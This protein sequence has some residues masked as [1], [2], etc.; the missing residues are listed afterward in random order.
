MNNENNIK[1]TNFKMKIRARTPI[2]WQSEGS[3][4][5]TENIIW[6][7]NGKMEN[8]IRNN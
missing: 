6:Q 1:T 7:R 8:D 5:Q 2:Y 4:Q 3:L